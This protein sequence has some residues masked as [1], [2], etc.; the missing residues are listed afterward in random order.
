MVLISPHSGQIVEGV[1]LFPVPV[2]LVLLSFAIPVVVEAVPMP[3]AHLPTDIVEVAPVYA[4]PRVEA[5][6]VLRQIH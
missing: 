2:L 6:H 5:A 4:V 1:Y 3:G